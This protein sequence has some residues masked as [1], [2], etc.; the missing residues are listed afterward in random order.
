MAQN[1]GQMSLPVFPMIVT[2]WLISVWY[3]E[4]NSTPG[5]PPMM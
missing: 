4:K 5:S 1:N 3:R 2:T